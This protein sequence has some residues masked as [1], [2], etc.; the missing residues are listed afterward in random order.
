MF[1]KL[2]IRI[3]SIFGMVLM[4]VI[5][6]RVRI[7]DKQTL[8]RLSVALTNFFYP[9]LIFST[10]VGTFSVAG[11]LKNWPLPAGAFMIMSVGYLYG[12]ASLRFFHFRS[13]KEKGVFLFQS[14]ISNY[15]FLPLPIVLMFWGTAGAAALILSALGSEI[16]VWTI[17]VL[18][19][20]GNRFRKE[21]LKHL[22]NVPV[23]AII[24]SFII[25]VI[26]GVPGLSSSLFLANR[27]SWEIGSS[28]MSVIDMFG[29]A[30]VPI[31][32]FV[33]GGWMADLKPGHFFNAK[34]LYLA[35]LR[36]IIIPASVI[37]LLRF[38]PSE[39][40]IRTI[41]GVVAVMP[42]ALA[43]VILSEVYG[44]DT[45]FA[46]AGVFITHLFSLITIPLWLTLFL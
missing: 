14:T 21:S 16:A 23:F 15:S 18:G 12:I 42:T 34:Q 36:L 37:G 17:G 44:G 25:I 46:A 1:L 6:Y 38:F 32:M 22:L 43:S 5:A 13:E 20:T 26:A 8:R 11:L 7:M 35:A 45:E 39:G 41:L 27:V 2:F 9:A 30:T 29:K 24:L 3:L 28:L 4:G 31:S 10:L 33:V 19:L 40:Y